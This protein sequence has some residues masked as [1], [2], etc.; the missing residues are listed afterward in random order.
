MVSML[1]IRRLKR[2]TGYVFE[3]LVRSGHREMGI[4]LW[5]GGRGSDG[6]KGSKRGEGK[7]A[8]GEKRPREEETIRGGERWKEER[9]INYGE[10]AIFG[11]V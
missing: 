10:S 2:D 3:E 5:K 8:R 7:T 4:N 11:V 9:D 6:R 1:S